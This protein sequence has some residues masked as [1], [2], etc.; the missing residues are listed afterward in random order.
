MITQNVF[1][2]SG[3]SLLPFDYLVTTDNI[4]L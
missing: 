1:K 2:K 3:I 4:R